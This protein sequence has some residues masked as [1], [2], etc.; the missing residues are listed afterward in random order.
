MSTQFEHETTGEWVCTRWC[1]GE[2]GPALD[3]GADPSAVFEV[4]EAL[5]RGETLRGEDGSVLTL[6]ELDRRAWT[7]GEFGGTFEVGSG[8]A[9]RFGGL[10]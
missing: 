7:F 1:S 2:R 8:D 4:R 5:E 6:E 10:R 3:F 9:A